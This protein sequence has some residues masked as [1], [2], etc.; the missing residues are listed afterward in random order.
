MSFQHLFLKLFQENDDKSPLFL[1]TLKMCAKN[2]PNTGDI[3]VFNRLLLIHAISG[4]QNIGSNR[5]EIVCSVQLNPNNHHRLI[6]LREFYR[7]FDY[8]LPSA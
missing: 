8:Y 7:L 5:S 4:A 3:H 2:T 6:H 1:I